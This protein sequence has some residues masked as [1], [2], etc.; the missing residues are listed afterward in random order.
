MTVRGRLGGRRAGTV[1]RL[2]PSSLTF[3]GRGLSSSCA[4]QLASPGTP[5]AR[6]QGPRVPPLPLP[7]ALAHCFPVL[8]L[9]LRGLV[10]SLT[11]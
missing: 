9:E 2:C 11:P 8:C 6:P 1:T 10:V 7:Q 3:P 4:E 5:R